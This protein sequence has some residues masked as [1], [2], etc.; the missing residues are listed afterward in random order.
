MAF[1][2]YPLVEFNNWT[3][4]SI[5]TKLNLIYSHV[6]TKI[7]HKLNSILQAFLKVNKLNILYMFTL[8]EVV[9]LTFLEDNGSF[10]KTY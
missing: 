7:D 1:C 2:Y 8:L 5:L 4:I 10:N 6:I 3:M 9:N